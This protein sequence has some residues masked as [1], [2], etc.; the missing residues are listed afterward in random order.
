MYNFFLLFNFYKVWNTSPSITVIDTVT[1]PIEE[2]TFPTVTLCPRGT[3]NRWG[4]VIK[5][6]DHM[7]KRCHNNG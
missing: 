7:K 3:N 6:F 5:V 1:Y 2:L 4:P